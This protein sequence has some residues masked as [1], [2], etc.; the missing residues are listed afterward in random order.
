MT[1]LG[2]N[3]SVCILHVLDGNMVKELNILGINPYPAKNFVLKMSP[4]FDICC[5]YSCGLQTRF[6]Y[7]A[8]G[9]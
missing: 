6:L 1:P 5:I 9:I 7:E 2:E 3:S 8:P 4:A